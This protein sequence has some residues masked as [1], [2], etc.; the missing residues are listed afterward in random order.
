MVRFC[1]RTFIVPLLL[2]LFYLVQNL[3]AQQNPLSDHPYDSGLPLIKNFSPKE[4]GEHSQNW[5]VVQDSRGVI[6][7]GNG[8][9][10]LEYDGVSWR[11]I[12]TTKGT[13]VRSLARDQNGR[14]YVGASGDFGYL[15]PDPLGRMRYISLRDSIRFEDR[16]FTEVWRTHTTS[17]GVY[18]QTFNKLF[19]WKNNRIKVWSTDSE[20]FLSAVVDD[21]LYLEHRQKGLLKLKGDSLELIPASTS[22]IPLRLMTILPLTKDSLL[23]CTNRQELLLLHRGQMKPFPNEC[24][25]F[26]RQNFLSA[27]AILPDGSI[28]LGTYKGGIAL[29]DRD[30]KWLNT[31]DAASGL[32]ENDVKYLY[33]DAGGI[34]W[35]ALNYGLSQ[36]NISSPF[37]YFTENQGILGLV[38]SLVRHRGTLYAATSQGIFYLSSTPGQINAAPRFRNV[39]GIDLEAFSFFSTPHNLLAATNTGLYEIKNFRAYPVTGLNDPIF[40][41]YRSG[42]DTTTLYAGLANGLAVYRY[43]QKRWEFESRIQAITEEIRSIT[44][45]KDGNLWLGTMQQG[46][47]K[48]V[49]KPPGS[50]KLLSIEK[51]APNV[52]LPYGQVM[53]LQGEVH[54]LTDQG[55]KSID[56]KTGILKP[57]QTLGEA[58]SK[59][60]RWI[61][62]IFYL[63]PDYLLIHNGVKKTGEYWLVQKEGTQYER[64]D[65]H[66]LRPLLYFGTIYSSFSGQNGI[67]WFGCNTGIVRF[68]PT[69]I[70]KQSDLPR[71]LI[72]RVLTGGDS[73]IFGGSLSTSLP[74]VALPFQLKA[75]R[76]EYA[77][78]SFEETSDNQYQ[79]FL[80]GF[81][82]NWSDWTNE[83]RKDYT[84][85]SEGDYTFRLR[86][87]DVTRRLSGEDIFNFKILPPWYR[88]WWAYVIYLFIFMI[89]LFTID[90]VQRD[91]LIK[92]EQQRAR[93]REA[94]IIH[95]KNQEL[96]QINVKL[97]TLLKSLQ[98][99]QSELLESESRF[100][101]VAE[102]ASDAIITADQKGVILFWN[103]MAETIFG[104]TPEEIV[105]QPLTVLMPERHRTG[106]RQGMNRLIKTG[107]TRISGKVVE[108]EAIR[109]SG[110]EF[111]I[112]LTVSHWKTAEGTF[113]TGIIRDITKRKRQQE[114]LT[115]ATARLEEAYQHKSEELEKARLLQLSMLPTQLPQLPH[116]EIDAY[117]KTATEVGGDYYDVHLDETKNLTLV[118]GDATGHGLEAGMLVTA[119]KSLFLKL[120]EEADIVSLMQNM[121]EALKKL[122]LKKLYMAFQVVRIHAYTLEVS[123][124]GMPPLFIYNKQKNTIDE[125]LLKALPLGGFSG[126]IYEKKTYSLSPGDVVLLFS[127][128]F[129]ERFNERGEMLGYQRVKAVLQETAHTSPAE[130]IEHLIQEGEA[131]AGEQAQHDDETFVVLKVK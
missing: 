18:Y 20:F 84:N 126:V 50:G 91:R 29:M 57:S 89:T 105:G 83:T 121:N 113:V 85:L 4:Y 110:E 46:I 92:R 127:D 69:R 48:V 19:R 109:K 93:I 14:I 95:D 8:H 87:R 27:A 56:E 26:L 58:L 52:F 61:S 117:M 55:L 88:S 79:F 13:R 101:A 17:Q 32:L 60:E 131:W 122:K 49:M 73:T 37:S 115:R 94:E 2:S 98:L 120:A 36:L 75:L 44:E 74:R 82:E 124:A 59:S 10:I 80:E 81:D 24:Q 123:T 97:E 112:E 21:T 103:S 47:F 66:S 16:D 90:R 96:Q 114:E 34:L 25:E 70:E 22:F 43:R 125:I 33:L 15:A 39:Q 7:F 107:E 67:S 65:M 1:F 99:S 51:L 42:I 40:C 108:I 53:I 102:S 62:Q 71:P 111:P 3:P 129:P 41:L 130:I 100:R 30:G 11:L 35:A 63:H 38:S 76:F 12:E 64:V 119:T 128:G 5:A 116:L 54:L 78:P 72:R 45:G 6:Y 28:A 9:G 31:F 77:L 118:I 68:D 86:A 23:L 106:H 104:Y